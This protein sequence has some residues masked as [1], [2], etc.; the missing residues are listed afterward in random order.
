MKELF[1]ELYNP[2]TNFTISELLETTDK[3]IKIEKDPIIIDI[4]KESR[5]FYLLQCRNYYYQLFEA[6]IV[7]ISKKEYQIL[8]DV[9]NIIQAQNI[10]IDFHDDIKY[11]TKKYYD[12]NEII[13]SIKDI[14]NLQINFI[15][16]KIF[17]M[18]NLLSKTKMMNIIKSF[19]VSENIKQ[20]F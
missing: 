17:S 20:I 2:K 3:R 7:Y 11:Y 19:A 10:F 18:K 12:K 15:D 16:Y 5:S 1:D 4:L 14:Y 8:T 9:E 6:L 13:E